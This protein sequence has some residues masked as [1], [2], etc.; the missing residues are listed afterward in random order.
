MAPRATRSTT[1]RAPAR[2]ATVDND[3]G[4]VEAANAAALAAA[5]EAA[6]G[7]SA[8]ASFRASGTVYGYVRVSSVEQSRFSN[9][10][11]SLQ[12]QKGSITAFLENKGWHGQ[13]LWIQEV[14]SARD[15]TKQTELRRVIRRIGAG[16]RLVA[17]DVTRISRDTRALL[18]ALH[19]I[20]RKG[21]EVW[22]AVDQL[23]YRG[24][25]GKHLFTIAVAVAENESNKL[26]ERTKASLA[27]CRARGDF[28]GREAPFGKQAVRLEN[29]RRVLRNNAAE[30][31]ALRGIRRRWDAF[32]GS[33][34]AFAR[35]LNEEGYTFRDREWT[36]ARVSAALDG[37]NINV[38]MG[39]L[40][41]ALDDVLESPAPARAP[42]PRRGRQPAR[43]V[44][45]DD[46]EEE[47]LAHPNFPRAPNY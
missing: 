36:A 4:N 27:Y 1:R 33:H 3:A 42:A 9:G 8:A 5:Q 32:E 37:P 46:E 43:L 41:A 26:S 25:A 24:T 14:V 7:S 34:A 47:P 23:Q 11:V 18:N 45:S 2:T 15:M 38:N 13:I 17:Y 29:G 10:H 22:S 19:D 39:G 40:R 6:H 28:L 44:L 35:H 12:Q 31:N 16:D 21:A 20:Y 30:S